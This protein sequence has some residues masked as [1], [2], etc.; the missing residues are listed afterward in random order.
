MHLNQIND[1]FSEHIIM[2]S[3]DDV[4]P[5]EEEALIIER[6]GCKNFSH[7]EFTKGMR[8]VLC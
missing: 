3:N 2:V 4:Y 7:E 5:L 8:N 1:I 6:R